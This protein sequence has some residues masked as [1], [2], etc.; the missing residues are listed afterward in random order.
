MSGW[1][2]P[3]APVTP[4]WTSAEIA[5]VTGGTAHGAFDAA[6]VS[7]DSREVAAGD[8]FVALGGEATDG[9]RFVDQ[10]FAAG[11]AGALVSR[12]IDRPHIRV[13]DTMHGLES[14]GGA[15]RAHRRPDLRSHRVG[16]QDRDQGGA[17]RSART[18]GA[19][20]GASLGEEL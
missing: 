16:R 4:L 1:N 5:S 15:A 17:L 10:A 11:A 6:G 19:R 2:Q 9:H 8:L 3:T 13:P 20:K 14:L 7:F 18:R 12:A